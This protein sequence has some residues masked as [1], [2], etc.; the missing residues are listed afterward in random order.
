MESVDSGEV[1][2]DQISEKMR[3]ESGCFDNLIFRST[4]H[5]ISLFINFISIH[6]IFIFLFYKMFHI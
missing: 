5:D 3:I 1:R 6:N 4:A 2:N